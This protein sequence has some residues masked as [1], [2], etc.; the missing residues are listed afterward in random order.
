VTEERAELNRTMRRSGRKRAVLAAAAGLVAG[1]VLFWALSALSSRAETEERRAD[2]AISGAEQLCQQVRQL[3]GACVVDPNSLK[4]DPGPAGPAG[5]IGPPGIPGPDGE[6]GAPGGVGPTGPDGERGPEGPAG[7]AGPAGPSGPAGPAGDAGPAG[8][9][10]PPGTHPE[11][12]TVLTTGGP[13]TM[14]GC[15]ED[16]PPS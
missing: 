12:V 3:G 14:A 2:A 1:A 5:E 9:A 6:D 13:V 7:P 16:P 11:V 15:V 8:P 4:G 10:C